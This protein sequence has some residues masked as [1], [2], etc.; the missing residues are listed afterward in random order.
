MNNEAGLDVLVRLNDLRLYGVQALHHA[1]CDHELEDAVM[2]H[3]QAHSLT[4]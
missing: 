2:C 3:E 1:S 4:C